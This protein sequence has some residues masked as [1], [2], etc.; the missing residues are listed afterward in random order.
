MKKVFL[1]FSISVFA[2]TLMAQVKPKPKPAAKAPLKTVASPLKTKLD[3]LSYSFG[4]SVAGQLKNVDVKDLNYGAFRKGLEDGM[5]GTVPACSPEQMN[6][7]LNAHF[8]GAKMK[9]VNAT[10]AASKK[11]LDDNKK[12]PGVIELPN[13][14]QYEI[15]KEGNGPIPKETDTVVA[16]YAGSLINGQEFDNSYKRGE[17][18]KRHVNGLVRGWTEALIRMPVGSKW[19]LFIPSDLGYGDYGAGQDIP[20]GAALIF[21]MELLEL[22]PDKTSVKPTN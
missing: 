16:H 13:G 15:L 17:P 14:L 11:F 9:E 12:R 20:G 10:K 2:T 18:L 19:K 6:A 7:A 4:Q 5:K 8:M 3:T 1:V 21:E 22:I